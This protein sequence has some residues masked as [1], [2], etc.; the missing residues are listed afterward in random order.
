MGKDVEKGG[1]RGFDLAKV[2]ERAESQPSPY[3]EFLRVPQLS[4]GIYQLPVGATDTQ[5]AHDEDEV[6]F[7]LKGRAT[8]EIDGEAKPL[9][10]NHGRACAHFTMRPATGLELMHGLEDEGCL[11]SSIRAPAT[12]TSTPPPTS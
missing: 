12:S 6:Y 11:T 8:L 9:G 4:C 3:L 1:W 7:V 5:S 2:V 10:L